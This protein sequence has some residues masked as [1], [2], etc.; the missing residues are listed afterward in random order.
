MSETRVCDPPKAETRKPARCRFRAL[1][2]TD[3]SS[4]DDRLLHGGERVYGIYIM[5]DG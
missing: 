4:N 1:C 3:A 5:V 2:A